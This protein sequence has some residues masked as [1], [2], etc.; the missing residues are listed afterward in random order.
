MSLHL[1]T[2]CAD[3]LIAQARSRVKA[4]SHYVFSPSVFPLSSYNV[5]VHKVTGNKYVEKYVENNKDQEQKYQQH[6]K[7]QLSKNRLFDQ[8]LPIVRFWPDL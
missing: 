6:K 2:C 7:H 8:D 5:Q 1:N 3:A 4:S